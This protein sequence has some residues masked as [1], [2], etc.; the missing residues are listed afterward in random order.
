MKTTTKSYSNYEE[1]YLEYLHAARRPSKF[2]NISCKD[3]I[4]FTKFATRIEYPVFRSE[5]CVEFDIAMILN[6]CHIRRLLALHLPY[7][8][9]H[10]HT[11]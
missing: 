1:C 4:C 10:S 2:S 3:N 8:I 7:L 5:K 6:S 9:V 11:I